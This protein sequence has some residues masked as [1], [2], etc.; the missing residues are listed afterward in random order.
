MKRVLIFLV[1]LMLN[2]VAFSQIFTKPNNT[3]GTISNRSS[4]DS[5]LYFPTACGVPTDSTFLYS[6]GF[7]KGQILSKAAK[8]YDS[9]GHHEYTWDPALKAWHIIDSSAG[10]GSFYDSTLMASRNKVKQDSIALV[11][12]INTK[13]LTLQQ[14]LTAGNQITTG[15]QLIKGIGPTV[16]Q[17]DSLTNINWRHKGY[18]RL[19]ADGGQQSATF[20]QTYIELAAGDS[21]EFR[22]TFGTGTG[23]VSVFSPTTMYS[24]LRVEDTTTITT[25]GTADSSNRAASTAWVKRQGYGPGGPGGATDLDTA[26]NATQVTITPTGGGAAAV[27]KASSASKAG[28][29]SAA[30][31]VYSDS[32]R[33]TVTAKQGSL[34][35]IDSTKKVG[36]QYDSSSWNNLSYFTATSEFS[37]SGNKIVAGAYNGTGVGT[38]SFPRATM[39]EQQRVTAGFKYT[40][41]SNGDYGIILGRVSTNNHSQSAIDVLNYLDIHSGSDFGKPVVIFVLNGTTLATFIGPTAMS[42]ISVG[43]SIVYDVLKNGALYAFTARNVTTGESVRYATI[44]NYLDAG[45]TGITANTGKIS[46]M[47]GQNTTSVAQI[48]RISITSDAPKNASAVILGNSITAGSFAGS[49]GNIPGV[50]THMIISAGPGDVSQSGIEHLYELW[51]DLAP[52]NV[53]IDLGGN[54]I[55]FGVSSATWQANLTKI[56]DTLIAHGIGVYWVLPTPRNAVD[57]TPLITWITANYPNRSID[58]FTPL[59]GSG[60][61]M[62]AAYNSG[63]GVH[64]NPSGD[65]VIINTF[66]ASSIYKQIVGTFLEY[67]AEPVDGSNNNAL[68]SVGFVKSVG[69]QQQDTTLIGNGAAAPLGVNRS[70]VNGANLWYKAFP[71]K[72]NSLFSGTSIFAGY[73]VSRSCVEIIQNRLGN[74]GV[75][76]LAVS[77]T[78]T[79]TACWK[80]AGAAPVPLNAPTLSDAAFNNAR[81]GFATAGVDSAHVFGIINAGARWMA[82]LQFQ[83]NIQFYR[84]TAGTIN[85]NVTLSGSSV[86]VLPADTLKDLASRVLAFT[87]ASPFW[88]QS[89]TTNETYTNTNVLGSTLAIGVWA[90]SLGG[91]RIQ[92]AVDGVTIGTYNP[93]NRTTN[94][95]LDGPSGFIRTGLQPDVVIIH[96]LADTLH[97]VTLTFLDGGA[98]G[99]VDFIGG[100]KTPQQAA[101]NPMYVMDIEHMSSAGYAVTGGSAAVQDSASSSRWASLIGTFPDYAGAFV[102][103]NPNAPF[104]PYNAADPAQTVDGIHPSGIG[105]NHLADAAIATMNPRALSSVSVSA[106]GANEQLITNAAGG[107]GA[108]EAKYHAALKQLDLGTYNTAGATVIHG[109]LTMQSYNSTNSFFGFNTQIQ[110][111]NWLRI[112]G[113][114]PAALQMGEGFMLLNFAATGSAGSTIAWNKAFIFTDAGTMGFDGNNTL[115]TAFLDVPGSTT[116]FASLRIRTGT[117]PTSPNTGDL[118]QKTD[119]HLYAFLGGAE[120]RLDNQIDDLGG[121]D[122]RIVYNN[123]GSGFGVPSGETNFKWDYTNHFLGLRGTPNYLLDLGGYNTV[124][125]AYKQGDLAIQSYNADNSAILA[126]A[127]IKS[128]DFKRIGT[129]KA[130]MIQMG[131]NGAITFGVTNTSSSAGSSITWINPLYVDGMGRLKLGNTVTVTP[132]SWTDFEQSTTALASLNLPPGARP[133]TGHDGDTYNDATDHHLYTYLN[134]SWQ[135][136]DGGGGGGGGTTYHIAPI[137]SLSRVADGLRIAGGAIVPQTPDATHPGLMPASQFGYLDSL[138]RGIRRDTTNLT[139]I[140]TPGINDLYSNAGGLRSA[141]HRGIGSVVV[142]V[143]IDS[144]VLYFLE[145]DTTF[146]APAP[147]YGYITNSIT[148]RKEWGPLPSATN[149]YGA[150]GT[151]SANRQLNGNSK[152]LAFGQ[153]TSQVSG[154]SVYSNSGIVFYGGGVFQTNNRFALGGSQVI[155]NGSSA[156]VTA[157]ISRVVFNPASA[158]ATYT[159]TL[160]TSGADGAIIK[161]YFGGTITSGAVVTS[162]TIVASGSDSIIQSAAPTTGLAGNYFSYVYNSSNTTWYREN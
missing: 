62:N 113:K 79:R 91:S 94:S 92:Y 148:G 133:T 26:R 156:S 162:L 76:N 42:S 138:I 120:T 128:D 54:D 17:F 69:V 139:Q 60:T 74:T 39:L 101:L 93:N 78:A 9:C 85:P 136:L 158:I 53:F 22:G 110:S 55:A 112:A 95:D 83:S 61:S 15:T 24:K 28:V 140:G 115:P 111:N 66:L 63:D 5:T 87:G 86:S 154:M 160:P 106:P 67:T 2:Y 47:V 75:I 135:Q 123:S 105:Q 145:N 134:G 82:A 143:D 18:F 70:I 68:A 7:G 137:D 109:D 142:G 64:P 89:L 122:M 131:V 102:R 37:I 114:K 159:L 11:A 6:Q 52:A 1:L 81:W 41:L 49:R 103:F 96:G 30:D 57:V 71:F 56:H 65:S 35:F 27:V 29:M 38:L 129:G 155:T 132:V 44:C 116:S 50:A 97:T 98:Y 25:M 40:T 141:M 84:T 16:L 45:G 72:N 80:L 59:K 48:G 127:E 124:G 119:N 147:N 146:T 117:A 104:G 14:I 46:I 151:L 34:I 153:F 161:I 43:D 32:I 19:Q 118:Y 90:D 125:A 100:L 77:S 150:D 12:A 4:N 152:S 23:K 157:G 58:I 144:T 73:L 10:G 33:A 36:T 108:A 31:K 88:R 3:Y 20:T 51:H 13:Q 130:S 21:I 107:L 126:N 99:G 8:Y 149:I 121:G